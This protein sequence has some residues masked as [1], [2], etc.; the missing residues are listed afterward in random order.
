MRTLRSLTETNSRVWF[1]LKDPKTKELFS[2]DLR[3]NNGYYL[4]GSEVT[5]ANCS[6]VMAVHADMKVAHVMIM[7]WN[8]SFRS[9]WQQISPRDP[10]TPLHVDYARYIAGESEYICHSSPFTPV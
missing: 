2:N 4:N 6:Y 8:A 1:Y 9:N 7:A 3:H 5:A 10:A